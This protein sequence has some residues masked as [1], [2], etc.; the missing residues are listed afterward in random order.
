MVVMPEG[1]LPALPPPLRRGRDP[2]G[3]AQHLLN[4]TRHTQDTVFCPLGAPLNNP[5]PRTST[6]LGTL[7]DLNVWIPRTA[8]FRA[9]SVRALARRLTD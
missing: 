3:A 8:E 7:H 9:L 5:F 6:C 1:A 4:Q 2:H